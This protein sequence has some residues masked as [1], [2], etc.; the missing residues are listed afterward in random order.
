M[1]TQFLVV[2]AGGRA[3]GLPVE[4][5]EAVTVPGAVAAVPSLEPAVR[6]VATMRGAVLPVVHLAALLAGQRCPADVASTA[7]VVTVEGRRLCLE[8]DDAEVVQRG[9]SLPVPPDRAVPWA[10]ALVRH[11]KEL[12]PLLDLAALSAR[13]F[14]MGRL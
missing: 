12:L 9:E 1:M 13:L 8:V 10:A 7:I 14:E 5:L 3:I 11:G 4:H 6:G 2:H